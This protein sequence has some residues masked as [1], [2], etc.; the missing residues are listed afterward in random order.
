M[1]FLQY[2]KVLF[3]IKTNDILSLFLDESSFYYFWPRHTQVLE[4]IS[5]VNSYLTNKRTCK[6]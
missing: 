2:S 5:F 1:Q 6:S 4:K 3:E